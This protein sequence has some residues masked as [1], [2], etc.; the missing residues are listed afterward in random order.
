MLKTVQVMANNWRVLVC[1]GT[2]RAFHFTP[3]QQ[4][5]AYAEQEWITCKVHVK[6]IPGLEIHQTIQFG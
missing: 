3:R 5:A 1:S 6:F 2:S 4:Y